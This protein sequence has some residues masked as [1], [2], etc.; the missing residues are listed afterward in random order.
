MPQLSRTYA[1]GRVRPLERTLLTPSTLE[2]LIAAPSLGE[3]ARVLSDAGWG[4]AQDQPGIEALADAHLS[5]ACKLMW[6]ITPDAQVAACFFIK[7]DM[8]NLKALF[9]ARLLNDDHPPLSENGLID[10]EKMKR[11][12]SD[13]NYALLPMDFRP[14]LTQIEQ[15]VAVDPD[16]FLVDSLLDKLMYTFIF[17]RLSEAKD[18]PDEIRQYFSARADATNLLITLRVGQMGNDADFAAPLFVT[19]GKLTENVLRQIV[20]DP[21]YILVAVKFLPFCAYVRRGMDLYEMGEGLAPLEKELE[22]YQLSIFRARRFDTDS[23][24]PL[25]GYLMAREREASAVRLII[26]AKVAR[27]SEDALLKRMRL[28]YTD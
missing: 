13:S 25:A 19:G 5:R 26:T 27:V 23:I 17:K 22:D 4:D 6:E 28:L 9:K 18:C 12:V 15:K 1:I 16:P 3:A 10:V 21:A 2:R 8:L 20:G 24:V 14:V 11:A 7:Y